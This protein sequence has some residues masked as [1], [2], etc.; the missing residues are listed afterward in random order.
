MAEKQRSPNYPGF[1][2]PEAILKA[3]QLYERDGKAAIP[4]EVAVQAWGY[5]G[6]N[7]ASLRALGALRQF[8]LL[9]QTGPG[10]VRISADALALLLEPEGSTEWRGAMS[11]VAMRPPIFRAIQKQYPDGVPSDAAVVAY[12]VRSANFSEDAARVVIGAYRDTMRIAESVL[13]MDSADANA[14]GG[15][16]EPSREP[17]RRDAGDTAR[18]ESTMPESGRASLDFPFPLI[19]GGQ[20]ILRLPRNMTSGDYTMLTT[21]ID[22]VLKGMKDALVS[23]PSTVEGES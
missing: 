20:A 6:L 12:L 9:E 18:R 19:S 13:A 5:Q 3:R 23:T 22:S 1:G 11:A 10:T 2:L 8:G 14:D 21:M 16:T 4:R 7:G 15:K 17:A